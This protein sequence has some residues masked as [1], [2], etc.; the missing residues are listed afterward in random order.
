MIKICSNLKSIF[1]ALYDNIV[2]RFLVETFLTNASVGLLNNF[3]W[4]TDPLNLALHGSNKIVCVSYWGFI[5]KVHFKFCLILTKGM[6]ARLI[7]FR[8][9]CGK[10]CELPLNRFL[11][12]DLHHKLNLLYHYP[13]SSIIDD[14]IRPPP[15][16]QPRVK[17][18][19]TPTSSFDPPTYKKSRPPTSILTI[20]SLTVTVCIC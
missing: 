9:C 6:R 3:S 16:F 10:Q 15:L 11:I 12:K 5:P 1:Q 7:I 17:K 13:L 4:P 2:H 14:K 19:S 20:R 8:Y 18:K